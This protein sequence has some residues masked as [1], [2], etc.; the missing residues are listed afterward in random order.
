MFWDELTPT[1]FLKLRDASKGFCVLPVASIERHGGHLPLGTD[2]FA[3]REICKR[4]AKMEPMVIFPVLEFGVNSE[5]GANPGAVGLRTDTLMLLLQ[6]LCDEI[7]RNGFAKILLYSTHGGNAHGLPFFVQQAAT[8]PRDYA[9]YYKMVG[10]ADARLKKPRTD[11]AGADSHAA[12]YE[13]SAIM[14]ARG[15]CVQ[16]DQVL[17]EEKGRKLGRLKHLLDL[18]IYTAVNFSSN[19]PNHYRSPVADASRE[20]GEELLDDRA[21]RLVEC[22]RAI[23]QDTEAPRLMKDF[24]ARYNQGGTLEAK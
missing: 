4:A 14:A 21:A 1:D 17:P 6:N 5:A 8:V 11:I 15:D 12:T 13:T 3:A 18:G 7:G 23:K 9:L 16:M 24:M 10:Y 20:L 22:A 19:F 2:S